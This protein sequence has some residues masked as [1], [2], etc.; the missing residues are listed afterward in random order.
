MIEDESR[1]KRSLTAVA[2]GIALMAGA[3]T[4]APAAAEPSPYR[5]VFQVTQ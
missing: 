3:L 1:M 4:A 2:S 5:C